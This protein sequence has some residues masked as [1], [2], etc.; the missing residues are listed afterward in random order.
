[1]KLYPSNWTDTQIAFLEK[2]FPAVAD[3]INTT[4]PAN[5]SHMLALDEANGLLRLYKVV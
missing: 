1:M 4:P 3:R 5:R 2:R